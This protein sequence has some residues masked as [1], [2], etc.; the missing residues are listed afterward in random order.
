MEIKNTAVMC[1]ATQIAKGQYITTFSVQ[2]IADLVADNALLLGGSSDSNKFRD[3]DVQEIA[4]E[5]FKSEYF[6][7]PISLAISGERGEP[8]FV[9]GKLAIR[10]KMRVIDGARRIDACAFLVSTKKESDVLK[11]RFPV[12]IYF[13][14][15]AGVAR[16][17]EQF[18]RGFYRKSKMDTIRGDRP[19]NEI[20]R[21]INS[22]PDASPMYAG[23]ISKD[24]GAVIYWNALVDSITEYFSLDCMTTEKGNELRKYLVE[25]LNIM[26]EYYS[27][28]FADPSAS[29]ESGRFVTTIYGT[30][31]MVILASWTMMIYNTDKAKW[32]KVIASTLHNIDVHDVEL[33]APSSTRK[34][35]MN[36]VK[37][38]LY[39]LI[40]NA[41]NL[42]ARECSSEYLEYVKNFVDSSDVLSDAR[43]TSRTMIVSNMLNAVS[44]AENARG[45]SLVNCNDDEAVSIINDVMGK[46]SRTYAYQVSCELKSYLD[47]LASNK[48]VKFSDT[49]RMA[50]GAWRL[51]SSKISQSYYASMDDLRSTLEQV[52]P[53]REFT[54]QRD[55]DRI[56]I[57]LVFLGFKIEEAATLPSDALQG[58]KV[59]GHGKEVI[60]DD[61]LKIEI[62]RYRLESIRYSDEPDMSRCRKYA[63]DQS[64]ALVSLNK[65]L[66]N[67]SAISNLR[68]R[69]IMYASGTDRKLSSDPIWRSGVYSRMIANG[70]MIDPVTKHTLTRNEQS[71][72]DMYKQI[73]Y[74]DK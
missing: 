27:T 47:W 51:N 54:T 39:S 25:C 68:K 62:K 19:A 7:D 6:F 30:Y 36:V 17:S 60:I 32:R 13:T 35:R 72:F 8:E 4:E 18:A 50:C 28:D 48:G 5:I 34:V 57:Q 56:I 37:T 52:I 59:I 40:K 74:S 69:L 63:I 58:N 42:N 71:D 45:V 65:T 20:V 67:S 41:M 38:R 61:D 33:C 29:V 66:P 46:Y 11:D 43:R 23:K 49:V 3:S 1:D 9:G 16:M 14:D 70:T 53:L 15:D 31:L 10:E 24:K 22:D 64:V 44:D 73:F 55:Y 12:I 21:E 2:Q 26:F